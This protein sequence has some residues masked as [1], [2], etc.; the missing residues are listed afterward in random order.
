LLGPHRLSD[1]TLVSVVQDVYVGGVSTRKV[2]VVVSLE[3]AA[4]LRRDHNVCGQDIWRLTEWDQPPAPTSDPE[5]RCSI[6]IPAER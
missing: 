4:L 5:L 2:D 1:Q 6:R 3:G